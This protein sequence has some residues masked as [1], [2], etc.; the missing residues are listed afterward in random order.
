P[1]A[2]ELG[3]VH[4]ARYPH[5]VGDLQRQDALWPQDPV[6]E[7]PHGLERALLLKGGYVT[8]PGYERQRLLG[9]QT[10]GSQA[11]EYVDVVVAGAGDE[12]VGS[13]DARGSQVIR[14]G[15][16]ATHETDVQSLERRS[17]RFVSVYHRDAVFLVQSLGDERA[18]LTTTDD[19]YVHDWVF[20]SSLSASASAAARRP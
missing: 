10:L 11:A 17:S 1:A 7:Q 6:Y 12:R 14:I 5:Y 20:Y 9:S 15:S 2:V 19:D 8:L 3:V 13:A 16:I 18:D 4:S